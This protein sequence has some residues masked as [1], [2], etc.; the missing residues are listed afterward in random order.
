MFMFETIKRLYQA[1]K[2]TD[3]GIQA[4]VLRGWITQEQADSLLD[5]ANA[6]DE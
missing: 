3:K 2:L 4:A 6:E 5:N 1:G